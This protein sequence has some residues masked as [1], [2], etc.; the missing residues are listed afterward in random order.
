MPKTAS[1]KLHFAGL[2]GVDSGLKT[3]PNYLQP[4]YPIGITPIS[5]EVAT[6]LIA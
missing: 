6:L 1:Q 5:T 4:P 3:S 2:A